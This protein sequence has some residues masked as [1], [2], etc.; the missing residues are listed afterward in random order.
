MDAGPWWTA[1]G[2]AAGVLAVGLTA[3]QGRLQPTG[4]P[5]ASGTGRLPAAAPLGQLPAKVRGWRVWWVTAIV[6]VRRRG[7]WVTAG[8]RSTA[9]L[10]CQGTPRSGTGLGGGG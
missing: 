2:S 8:A 4:E 7:R 9:I 1:A 10:S 5:S 6:R 3:G